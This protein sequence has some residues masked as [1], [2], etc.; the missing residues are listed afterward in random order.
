M[1]TMDNRLKDAKNDKA[2]FEQLE[3]YTS[4]KQINRLFRFIMPFKFT[5]LQKLAP[6]SMKR[7][8]VDMLNFLNGQDNI[9]TPEDPR[10]MLLWEDKDIPLYDGVRKPFIVP[11]LL[12]NKKAPAVVIAPGGAYINCCIK[13]EGFRVA[14]RF[15]ELGFHAIIVNYRVSPNRYPCPQLDFIRAMQ[16]VRSKAEEWGIIEDK[17]TAIGFSAGGHLVTSIPGL[18]E[19]LREQTG[20]LKDINGV[21]DALIGGYPMIDLKCQS[22]GIT[23][24]M[25]FLGDKL[26]EELS[27]KLSVQNLIDENYPPTFLFAEEGDNTCP[28]KTNCEVAKK[29]LDKYNVPNEM[30]V[31]KGDRHGFN[32]GEGRESGAW[33]ESSIAFLK[34]YNKA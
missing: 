34:K 10:S 4:V 9:I 6:K 25:I 2:A 22:M 33:V 11:M 13:D 20:D 3:K 18:F 14:E 29:V 32:L 16:V 19:E 21:P 28:P 1:L 15:N 7:S 30:H 27:R 31:Y 26:T 5:T 12:E 8:V 17:I 23:C 24:D